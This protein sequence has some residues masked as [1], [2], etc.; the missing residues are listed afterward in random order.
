MASAALNTTRDPFEKFQQSLAAEF[1]ERAAVKP[2]E[3]LRLPFT[4]SAE[5]FL[6]LR[7][8]PV[9]DRDLHLGILAHSHEWE[10]RRRVY[11][12]G[13]PYLM[14]RHVEHA[15]AAEWPSIRDDKLAEARAVFASMARG[16]AV[17]A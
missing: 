15:L 12:G 14:P 6:G 11:H 3:A 7:K 8:M 13:R 10:Q 4:L 5:Q 16:K 2:G 17:A 9:A 1:G